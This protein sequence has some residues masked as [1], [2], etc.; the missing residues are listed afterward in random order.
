[1]CVYA[2]VYI[3][4]VLLLLGGEFKATVRG[5][6]V[7]LC[8]FVSVLCVCVFV[9]V[10]SVTYIYVCKYAVLFCLQGEFN[11]VVRAYVCVLHAHS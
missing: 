3:R 5:L 8:F 7:H 4:A 1:M 2:C 6:C 10:C 11:A 9:Y